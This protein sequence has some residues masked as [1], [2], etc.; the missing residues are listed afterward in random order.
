MR[1]RGIKKWRGLSV[2]STKAVP[3]GES[4]TGRLAGVWLSLTPGEHKKATPPLVAE[5]AN[6][7]AWHFLLLRVT[8][9]LKNIGLVNAL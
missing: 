6:V 9:I 4:S 7:R 3:L 1:G 8:F 2:F 5:R